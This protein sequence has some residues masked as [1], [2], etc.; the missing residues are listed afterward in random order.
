MSSAKR[1]NT[2]H[3][4][5]TPTDECVPQSEPQWAVLGACA[6]SCDRPHVSLMVS[7]SQELSV[8]LR[9]KDKCPPNLGQQLCLGFKETANTSNKEGGVQRDAQCGTFSGSFKVTP[10]F[11]L[12]Y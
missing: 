5:V 10:C 9:L 1:K 11:S 3:W 4:S 2:E 8:I 6:V 12:E 7:T